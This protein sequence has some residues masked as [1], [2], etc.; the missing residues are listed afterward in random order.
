[1]KQIGLEKAI[2]EICISEAQRERVILTRQGKPVALIV[3]LEGSDTELL[4]L[5]SSDKFWKLITKRR[6]QKT[7]TR[8]ELEEK[9]GLNDNRSV[10][11]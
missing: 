9:L 1:M 11:A 8:E 10:T 4:E 7:I 6:T 5:G 2:L 3:G